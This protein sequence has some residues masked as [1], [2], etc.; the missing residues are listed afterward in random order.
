MAQGVA[1]L[2]SPPQRLAEVKR[3]TNTALGTVGVPD[4]E[5]KPGAGD[6]P[7]VFAA[8]NWLIELSKTEF[9][10]LELLCR[11]SE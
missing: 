7:A 2:L 5:M 6:K 11:C 4:V 1:T 9:L 3:V 10:L 8:H